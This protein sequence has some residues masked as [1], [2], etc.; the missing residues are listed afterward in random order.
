MAAIFFFHSFLEEITPIFQN[1]FGLHI[2]LVPL[3]GLQLS[4]TGKTK[5]KVRNHLFAVMLLHL[6]IVS[7]V[8]GRERHSEFLL[9]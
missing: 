2:G 3:V 7:A 6:S 1:R 5:R 4:F 8:K 9:L